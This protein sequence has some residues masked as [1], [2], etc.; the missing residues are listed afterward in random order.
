MEDGKEGNE[1]ENEALIDS[2]R[3]ADLSPKGYK[4]G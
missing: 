4:A 3:H 2:R 1:E